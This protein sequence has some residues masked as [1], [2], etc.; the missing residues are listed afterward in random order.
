MI[1]GL[2]YDDSHDDITAANEEEASMSED[3]SLSDSSDNNWELTFQ[4]AL[5]FLFWYSNCSMKDFYPTFFCKEIFFTQPCV[6]PT[7]SVF[8]QPIS[9]RYQHLAK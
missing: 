1:T 6:Y 3:F 5:L 8:I 4:T 7:N 9:L 2:A